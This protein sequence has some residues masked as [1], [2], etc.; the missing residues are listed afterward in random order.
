MEYNV[1][2]DESCHLYMKSN[3]DYMVV[4]AIYCP[5][6][7][8]KKINQYLKNI[9]EKYGINSQE[10]L[11]WNK[12]SRANR[13]LY[14]DV[15]D[16]FFDKSELQFRAIVIDKRTLKHEDYHHTANQFYHISYYLMLKYIIVPGNSY[17]IFPDI[18][19]SNSY[20]NHQ[21]VKQFLRSK[22]HD[23]FGK[24]V[25]QVTPIR[26]YESNILQLSDILIGALSYYYRK[27]YTNEAKVELIKKIKKNV[28]YELNETT[29]YHYSKFNVFTW[30]ADYHG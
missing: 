27:L 24:T 23:T 17:N 18:K 28:P 29:P 19:D 12:I 14:N 2:C 6:S 21:L 4:G 30:E 25:R 15:I 5:K 10:E 13:N 16:Y 22:Y 20:Y 26:S 9:K 3:G 7:K 8:V 1:Y 11:K